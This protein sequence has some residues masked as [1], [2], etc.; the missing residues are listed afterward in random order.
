MTDEVAKQIADR[1]QASEDEY[2]KLR[3][4]YPHI[5]EERREQLFPTRVGSP[6]LLKWMEE[7]KQREELDNPS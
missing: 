3:G 6:A 5:S 2:R 4:N 1:L 7:K